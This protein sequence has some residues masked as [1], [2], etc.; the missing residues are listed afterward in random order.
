MKL[1]KVNNFLLLG[2]NF[3]VNFYL[4]HYKL[5]LPPWA[6]FFVN[7]CYFITNFLLTFVNFVMNFFLTS[8]TTCCW[9]FVNFFCYFNKH[10]LLTF[11]RNWT[12]SM[13]FRMYRPCK[14]ELPNQ[15]RKCKF[16]FQMLW[17]EN[18]KLTLCTLSNQRLARVARIHPAGPRSCIIMA[19]CK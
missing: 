11:D 10:I 7:F 12:I 18:E 1:T 13:A 5:F 3:F 14:W 9:L 19:Y 8:I 15:A 16:C 4:P 6:D 17:C 2:N